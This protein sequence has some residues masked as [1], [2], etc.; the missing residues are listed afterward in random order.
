ME[1]IKKLK[2]LCEHYSLR[3]CDDK[4][5]YQC[6]HCLKIIKIQISSHNELIRTKMNLKEKHEWIKDT[7]ICICGYNAKEHSEMY[8]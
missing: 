3:R 7:Y 1:T 6:E 2:E 8:P 5:N 4:G